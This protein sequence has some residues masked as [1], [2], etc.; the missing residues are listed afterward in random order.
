VDSQPGI[1][2][3]CC[4]AAPRS[5]GPRG[6]AP[7]GPSRRTV[8]RRGHGAC[9]YAHVPDRTSV[10]PA[11]LCNAPGRLYLAVGATEPGLLL[12]SAP[13]RCCASSRRC[14]RSWPSPRS[15]QPRAS[16]VRAPALGSQGRASQCQIR[17]TVCARVAAAAQC[18]PGWR[19]CMRFLLIPCGHRATD[20][21]G[22]GAATSCSTSGRWMM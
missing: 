16:T 14:S 17:C 15:L 12:R 13:P 22:G 18:S 20:R 10:R 6:C 5:C 19:P 21:G 2:G 3:G 7:R 1:G 9:R 4:P 8:P 11:T